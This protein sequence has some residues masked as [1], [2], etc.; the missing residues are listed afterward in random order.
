MELRPAT[1]ARSLG[2]GGVKWQKKIREQ[3]GG[4]FE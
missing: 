2:G 4:E 3:R 1:A